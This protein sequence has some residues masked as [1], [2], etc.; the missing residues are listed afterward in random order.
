MNFTIDQAIRDNWKLLKKNPKKIIGFFVAVGLISIFNLVLTSQLDSTISN[1]ESWI[2]GSFVQIA[3]VTFT[4][5]V[6]S[7]KKAL[8]KNRLT[9]W[10]LVLK[11]ITGN[12]LSTVIIILGFLALIIPGIVFAVRL[13]YISFLII[14][15]QLG[16]IQ[17]IKASW[18]LTKNNFYSLLGFGIVSLLLNLFGV[19]L[20]VFGLLVTV[21]LTSLASAWVYLKLSEK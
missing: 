11:L 7:K 17:A 4:V 20:L 8:I 18:K 5:A 15:K 10:K 16:P 6:V 19:L 14:D 3:V 12:L 13:Q 9:D 1:I 21:P 2:F